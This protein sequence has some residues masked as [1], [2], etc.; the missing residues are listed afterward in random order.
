MSWTV[1]RASLQQRRTSLIWYSIGLIFYGWFIVWYY[2]QFAGNEEFFE[3]IQ[4]VMTEELLAAFGASGLD[5]GTFGGFLGVEYLS[6]IW[7]V[8]AGA[9]MIS[10]A[11][12]SIASEVEAGTMELTLTQPVSRLSLALSRWM[13]M[14]VYAVFINL[15]TVAPIWTAAINYDVEVQAD[16]MYM[17]FAVGLL[18]TLAV[19]GFAFM[20]S[21]ISRGGGRVAAI[22]S[23]LLGAMWLTDFVAAVNEGTEFLDKFTIFHYWQPAAIIDDATTKPETWWVFGV[24]AV[25]FAAIGV[26]RFLGRDVAA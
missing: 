25:L 22:T 23:G 7:V 11:A 8:I 6:I 5:F 16:A 4:D 10:F 12:K 21:A 2:P 24:A 19:G 17:L 9:A 13:S 3:Q 20:V 1:F 14:A 26:W 18:L 15:A